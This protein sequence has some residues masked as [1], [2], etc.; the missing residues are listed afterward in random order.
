MQPT[1]FFIVS[2]KKRV[3]WRC[4]CFREIALEV[5][6]EQDVGSFIVRDSTSHPNCFALSVK[7]PKFDNPSGISHYLIT[8]GEGGTLKLKVRHLNI[9]LFSTVFDSIVTSWCGCVFRV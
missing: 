9:L 4:D 5:L 3:N 2:S 1:N 6:S 7:V 8:T